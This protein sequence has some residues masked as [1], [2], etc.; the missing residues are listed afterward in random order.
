MKNLAK[1][2]TKIK[3][4]PTLAITAKAKSMKAEG[5][6]VIGFGAGE[7]DFDTPQNIKDAAIKAIQDGDTKYTPAGGTVELKK[8]ICEKLKKDNSLDYAP[9][10]IVVSCG[11]KHSLYNIAQ[12]L[13]EEGDE[14]VIPAPYW[15]SYP[16]QAILNDATPV[17][18]FADD[19]TNF[20]VTPQQLKDAI[21]SQTKAFLLNSPSNPTGVGYTKNE[22][23]DLAQVCLENDVYIIS[24][25]IYEK[26]VFNG[27]E[28]V[29]V[30][31]LSPEI[32]NI[33]LVV[34]GVSKCYSMTGWRMGYTAGPKEIIQAMT[35]LQGQSTS[36]VCSITQAACI[37]ALQG[38]QDSINQMLV[39]FQERRDFIVKALNDM[40]GVVCNNPDGAFYVFP[41][42]SG[43]FGKQTQKGKLIQN[44][45]D[46]CD[47]LLEDFLVA[48]VAG[49][50][51][52]AEGFMRLSYATS[53]ENIKKGIKR[54]GQAVTEL[55]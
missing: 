32:K 12:V 10:Q 7:P 54:I 26:I 18:L 4:S 15:V 42:I 53:L 34:N 47:Y 5:I 19:S 23:Q 50:G 38:P 40:P 22:I 2:I 17:T 51:F 24:D 8:A 48:A 16:D 37:E 1:R 39:A 11:A 9:D 41:N 55:Q 52:G 28:H 29:S 20:K 45:T 13:F 31:S 36:N 49:F 14:I 35:K 30:A 33:S 25:E 46:F 27:F 21:T 6:D 44:S 3:P 43:L